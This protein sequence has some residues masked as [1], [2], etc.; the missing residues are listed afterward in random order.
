MHEMKQSVPVNNS[1]KKIIGTVL[2]GEGVISNEITPTTAKSCEVLHPTPVT[3][4]IQLISTDDEA[5]LPSPTQAVGP[6]SNVSIISLS[7]ASLG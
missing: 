4:A 6:I 7:S 1:E 2:V 3:N 5:E